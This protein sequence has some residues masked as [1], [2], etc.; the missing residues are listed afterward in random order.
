MLAV[1]VVSPGPGSERKSVQSRDESVLTMEGPGVSLGMCSAGSPCQSLHAR[2][3][4][5]G[6][7]AQGQGCYL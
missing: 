3:R 4:T 7:M 1:A 2:E 6:G 5:R